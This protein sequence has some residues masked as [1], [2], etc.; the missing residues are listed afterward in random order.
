MRMRPLS[1]LAC[2]LAGSASAVELAR[3]DSGSLATIEARHAGKPF[4]LSLWSVN[5]CGHCI[6][7]LTLLG[8]LAKTD[9]HLPLILVS[10]DNPDDSAAIRDT[11]HRLGLA[12]AEVWVFDDPIPE[13]LRA[14]VDPSW[15]GDLPRSYL[16]DKA[17]R[18]QTV[19]GVLDEARLRSWLKQQ[20]R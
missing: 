15:Q 16:Y 19:A 14:S 20:S 4:I 1:L 13:R 3:F 18:R 12:Q 2:L 9:R 10:V 6:E 8:K 5:W 7:E 11:L 17:H